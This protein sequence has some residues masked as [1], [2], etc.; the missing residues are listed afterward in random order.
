MFN[1]YIKTK[2]VNKK[3][4]HIILQSKKSKRNIRALFPSEINIM[5]GLKIHKSLI[6]CGMGA[7][8]S[9]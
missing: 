8:R 5:A 6:R 2:K 3:E 1:A 4:T 7:V 9:S